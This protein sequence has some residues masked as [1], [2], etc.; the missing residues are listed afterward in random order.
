VGSISAIAAFAQEP[1]CGVRDAVAAGRVPAARYRQIST[2]LRSSHLRC[3]ACRSLHGPRLPPCGARVR[4]PRFPFRGMLP[5]WVAPSRSGRHGFLQPP[6][7]PWL[8]GCAAPRALRS[9]RAS[10]AY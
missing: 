6:W 9:R 8:F 2:R 7:R 10:T 5:A 3:A 4:R 1:Q